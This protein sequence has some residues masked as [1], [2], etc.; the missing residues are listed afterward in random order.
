MTLEVVKKLKVVKGIAERSIKFI[1]EYH[2][3]QTKNK[4]QRQFILEVVSDYSH[5]FRVFFPI[6]L[7][8]IS[9]LSLVLTVPK[10]WI[11]G[12]HSLHA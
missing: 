10:P 11:M 7:E 5:F 2:D 3:S 6:S 9:I 4:R 8:G 12:H 1:T